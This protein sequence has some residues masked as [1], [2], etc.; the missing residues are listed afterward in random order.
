MAFGTHKPSAMGG[1]T[2]CALARL[3]VSTAINPIQANFIMA[4]PA[5]SAKP[6]SMPQHTVPHDAV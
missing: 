1:F 5:F 6:R 4:A 2:P 3:D